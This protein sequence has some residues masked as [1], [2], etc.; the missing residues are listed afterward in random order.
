MVVVVVFVAKAITYIFLDHR[1]RENGVLIWVGTGVANDCGSENF[2]QIRQWHFDCCTRCN[3]GIDINF[4]TFN[5]EHIIIDNKRPIRIGQGGEMTENVKV[6]TA[7]SAK[8]NMPMY[9]DSLAA[10]DLSM[11]INR[12]RFL[13]Q[14]DFERHS[15]NLSIIVWESMVHVNYVENL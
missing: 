8:S 4:N 5:N 12:V 15:R 9:H 6:L 3:S 13:Y 1:F 7:V 11:R 2:R 14:L 10:R